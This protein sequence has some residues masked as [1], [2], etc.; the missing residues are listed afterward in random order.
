MA[1]LKS[2]Q[3]ELFCQL[4]AKGKSQTEAYKEAYPR[5]Q[6]WKEASVWTKASALMAD[7]KVSARC[8]ELIKKAS[9]RAEVDASYVLRRL[10]EIDQMDVLDILEDDGTIKPVREWPKIWRQYL[11]GI[12][13]SEIIAGQGDDKAVV[14]ILKKI[15]WPDKLKN[16]ELLGKH[17]SVGAFVEKHDHTSSDGS[18]TPKS[19]DKNLAESLASKLVD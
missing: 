18:M 9:E 11:T 12:D 14:S 15:K 4:I 2:M 7:V 8:G 19:V 13:V 17:L 1:S 5:S 10:A 3:Q 16:L 6:K